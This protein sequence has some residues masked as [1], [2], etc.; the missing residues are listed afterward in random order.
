LRTVFA[1]RQAIQRILAEKE[2]R[3]FVMVGPCSIHDPEAALEYARRLKPLAEEL[4]K[5]ILVVMRA[6]LEKPVPLSTRT[7]W[8]VNCDS[9]QQ[10]DG[11][12]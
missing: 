11:K 8:S 12:V 10:S 2:D 7:K 3:I 5:D 1:A 6:Y 9:A 4:S